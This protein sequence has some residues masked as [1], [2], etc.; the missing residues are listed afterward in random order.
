M[1]KEGNIE[2]LRA[3]AESIVMTAEDF[4]KEYGLEVKTEIMPD[5]DLYI[6]L[7]W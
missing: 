6:T 4:I 7:D 2:I 3:F 5:T 1:L